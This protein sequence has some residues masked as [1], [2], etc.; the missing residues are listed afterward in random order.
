MLTIQHNNVRAFGRGN[1]FTMSA[2]GFGCDQKIWRFVAAAFEAD[3]R[4]V[5]FDDAGAGGCDLGSFS[6]EK[7]ASLNGY[8]GSH[9]V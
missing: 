5:L 4:T 3:F 6:R 2:H 7:Y 1:R 9:D 8:G